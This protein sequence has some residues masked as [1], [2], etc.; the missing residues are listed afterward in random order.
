MTDLLG[1]AITFLET[2]GWRF[3]TNS[4]GQWVSMNYSGKAGSW[5][6]WFQD[7]G[8][9]LIAYADLPVIV[10]DPRRLQVAEFITY[11]NEGLGVG[12]FELAFETGRV[13]Y[14]NGFYAPD[15]D[16][17]PTI[18][19]NLFQVCNWT[20]ND[21]YASLMSLVFGTQTATSAYAEAVECLEKARAER[22]SEDSDKDAEVS[23]AEARGELTEVEVEVEQLLASLDRGLDQPTHPD[24]GTA[25]AE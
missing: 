13:R 5:L 9:V 18:A 6:T 20:M 12:N 21:Y 17:S 7:R 24:D 11:V 10:P 2:D 23:P 1:A 15:G 16:L 8:S 19:R 3:A 4:E 22:A 14:K 25:H